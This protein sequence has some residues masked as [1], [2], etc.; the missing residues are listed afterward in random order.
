[1]IEPRELLSPEEADRKKLEQELQSYRNRGPKLRFSFYECDTDAQVATRERKT[2]KQTW[3]DDQILAYRLTQKRQEYDRIIA[4]APTYRAR[5]SDV[6]EYRRACNEYLRQLRLFDIKERA[7]RFGRRYE[8]A[9]TVDNVGTAPAV[10]LAIRL[11]FPSGSFLVGTEDE[12]DSYDG[13]YDME[14]PHE[15]VAEWLRKQTPYNF[16][17]GVRLPYIPPLGPPAREPQ[18][19]GPLYDDEDRSRVTYTHPKLRHNDAWLLPSLAVYIPPSDG[20]GF[21]IG[22]ELRADDLPGTMSSELNVELKQPERDP[23]GFC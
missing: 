9:F 3:P 11:V 20:G 4:A 14:P 22:Y 7:R 10:D 2:G 23:E 6:A 17:A 1:M 21:S 12:M 8:F 16:L 5:E 19:R 15:P 13:F 18:P